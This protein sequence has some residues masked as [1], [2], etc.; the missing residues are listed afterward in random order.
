MKL[1]PLSIGRSQYSVVSDPD[2]E[3]VR[4]RGSPG[5]RVAIVVV[6]VVGAVPTFTSPVWAKEPTPLRLTAATRNE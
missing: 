3:T 1:P 5:V 2:T 4:F 6:V